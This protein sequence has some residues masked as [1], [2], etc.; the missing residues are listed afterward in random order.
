MQP[1]VA[2]LTAHPYVI[3]APLDL[4]QP[5]V[6]RTTARSPVPCSYGVSP[7]VMDACC[8]RCPLA[9]ASVAYVLIN[10]GELDHR[11]MSFSPS[12]LMVGTARQHWMASQAPSALIFGEI[13]EPSASSALVSG[14]FQ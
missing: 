11:F 7:S 12:T 6:A 1:F 14:K 9:H 4:A 8:H 13:R 5:V 3:W 10:P 2:S